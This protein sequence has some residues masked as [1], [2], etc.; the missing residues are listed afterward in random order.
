[1]E[2]DNNYE[3]NLSWQ[4]KSVAFFN[5]LR[6]EIAADKS[7]YLYCLITT[8]LLYALA[9]YLK[10]PVQY[11]FTTYLETL[12][13]ACYSAGLCGA[14]TTICICLFAEKN[15]PPNSFYVSSRPSFSRSVEPAQF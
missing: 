1:M 6:E 12:Y 15:T 7:I 3:L 8:I 14:V 10:L 9:V 11:S 4:K 2:Q 13:L 5:Q